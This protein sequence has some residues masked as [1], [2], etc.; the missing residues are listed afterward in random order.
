MRIS[1]ILIDD[2]SRSRQNLRQLLEVYCPDIDVVAEA[3][4][5]TEALS[6]IAVHQPDLLFL[7]IEM[8][9]LSGFDLLKMLHSPQTFEVIF[10]T[11]FDRYGIQAVKACAI[12]YLLKPINIIELC[13]AVNKAFGQIG[14][15][16]ENEKLRE[17]MANIDRR[18]EE[19]RI[20]VPLADKIEFILISKILRLEAEGNYTHFYLEGGKHYLVCKTLKEYQDLL[21]GY[22]FI[23]THQSHVINFKK[24]SAYVKKD[25]GYI[26]ME[27]GSSVPISRQKKD[28]VLSH[29][30]R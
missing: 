9:E 19:Q 17:L 24:I 15:K 14:P 10:V 23:R 20:A 25:G 27:D 18:E 5:P 16:K 28:E 26:S 6:L 1:T 3:G 13:N 2:E 29:I 11:A 12:D 22:Q 4:S 30:L 21:E 7:D 8:G